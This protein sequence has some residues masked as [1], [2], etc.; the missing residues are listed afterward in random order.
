MWAKNKKVSDTRAP[1]RRRRIDAGPAGSA[2][3]S[4][5]RS[6]FRR[7]ST[8][9]GSSSRNIASANELNGS[10]LSPRAQAHHLGR[11]RR[12]LLFRLSLVAVVALAIYLI[13]SQIAAS[14]SVGVAQ[15]GGGVVDGTPY[16]KTV[17]EYFS[18]RPLARFHPLLDQGDLRSYL[19]EKHP[20]IKDTSL[21]LTGQFGKVHLAVTYRKPVALW[22]LSGKT[23]YVDS[24]G[25]VFAINAYEQPS[26]TITDGN[27]V[28]LE[29][30]NKSIIASNRFLVF[31]GRIVGGF[32]SQGYT[33][34]GGLLPEGTT[35]Q[36]AISIDG[37]SF[38]IKMT[39]DRSAGE[40]VEDAIRVIAY[41]QG[42]GETPEYIDVRIKSKAY[43]K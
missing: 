39:V 7:N 20:E 26:V 23:M 41:M 1:R 22:Q 10:I 6:S 12:R 9:I 21:D 31:V 33:V 8:I 30:L 11:H 38:P 40:Q 16:E 19:Q 28:A 5:H 32:E 2:S 35:R 18:N 42:R 29:K 24:S 37:V 25:V 15:A 17:E 3:V 43:Y 27:R 4:S 14:V 34:T 13:I 36:I